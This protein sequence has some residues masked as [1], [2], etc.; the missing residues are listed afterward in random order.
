MPSSL[1]S[2]SNCQAEKAKTVLPCKAPRSCTGL[3]I[4]LEKGIWN[5]ELSGC[6]EN[7]SCLSLQ[8]AIAKHLSPAE[9]YLT[10]GVSKGT[11]LLS[12]GSVLLKEMQDF[13]PDT[14]RH[15][16]VFHLS[17]MHSK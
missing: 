16:I 2:L 8:H 6:L 9:L 7:D 12:S 13:T 5:E 14:M 11:F 15:V 1:S 10:L 17:L 4:R 3:L